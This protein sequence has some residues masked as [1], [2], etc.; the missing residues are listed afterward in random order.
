LNIV[1]EVVAK[2]GWWSEGERRL[3]EI[4]GKDTRRGNDIPPRP[5]MKGTTR[6]VSQFFPWVNSFAG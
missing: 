2:K 3:I 4:K 5:F 1:K 6:D